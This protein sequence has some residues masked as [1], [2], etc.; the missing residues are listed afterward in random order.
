MIINIKINII[1]E[2]LQYYNNI[3]I[4]SYIKYFINIKMYIKMLLIYMYIYS[5]II[6]HYHFYD[7]YDKTNGNRLNHE[8]E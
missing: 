3:T 5:I 4:A 2:Y 8:N 6:I 7:F 1:T